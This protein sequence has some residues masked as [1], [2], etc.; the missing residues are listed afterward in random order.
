MP[1]QQPVKDTLIAVMNNQ[2]DFKIAATKHWYRIPIVTKR[3][4]GIVR[5][6]KIKYIAFYQ[7]K[8]F[9]QEAWL[10]KWFAE[11]TGIS[12][13]KREDLFP[14]ERK[15]IKTGKEYYK[16]EFDRLEE[17]PQPIESSR[18]RRITF[19]ET[20]HR[21]LQYATDI[22]DLF[23]GSPLEEKFW[24]ALKNEEIKAE[25][26]FLVEKDKQRFFID[27]ALFCKAGNIGVECD[28]DTHHTEKEDVYEDK[29]RSNI[30]ESL[31][32]NML[33]YTTKDIR[34]RLDESIEQIKYTVNKFGGQED[35]KEKQYRYLK[36]D[37]N[38]QEKMF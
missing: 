34:E 11:V 33:R 14:N 28:S 32:W 5:D 18:G 1:E 37:K 27:F 31:G 19:I 24:G 4:T 12:V 38:D 8:V 25:R 10:I 26:E 20:T 9:K 29:R 15:N 30:L 36:L 16:I 23:I 3:S 7:T 6:G 17:L 2:R 21:H 13:V 35:V 22:N